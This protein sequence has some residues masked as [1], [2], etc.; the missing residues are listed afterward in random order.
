MYIAS[1][2]VILFGCCIQC[3]AYVLSNIGGRQTI[4]LNVGEKPIDMVLVEWLEGTGTQWIDTG[5]HA[6]HN[7]SAKIGCAWMAQGYDIAIFAIDNGFAFNSGFTLEQY[8]PIRF[9]RGNQYVQ[10]PWTRPPI[11][12]FYDIVCSRN[13]LSIDGVLYSIPDTGEFYT[14]GTIPLYGWRRG[15]NVSASKCRISYVQFY[16]N[17]EL[18]RDFIPVRIGD[19]DSAV[20]FM[21]DMVTDSLFGNS[22]TGYFLIGPDV[23][24]R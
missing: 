11:G 2:A 3:N 14:T 9:V 4:E 15:N 6:T 18:V 22:G 24:D 7:T 16:E 19:G 20:G 23:E 5:I 1:I 10:G 17:G 21:Y 8:V 12:Q 13:G